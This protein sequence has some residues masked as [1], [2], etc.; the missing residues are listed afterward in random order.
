MTIRKLQ[1]YIDGAENNDSA[2]ETYATEY[3]LFNEGSVTNSLKDF[4]RNFEVEIFNSLSSAANIKY[5]QYTGDYLD[6]D[7]QVGFQKIAF[8]KLN[9]RPAE[10][11]DVITRDLEMS[12]IS[13]LH[14]NSSIFIVFVTDNLDI[15][16]K[17]SNYSV[18]MPFEYLKNRND[19]YIYTTVKSSKYNFLDRVK[20][21]LYLNDRL[22]I[23]RYF[24]SI[25]NDK[26]LVEDVSINCESM[27][28]LN[29]KL[30]SNNLTMVKICIDD[31][32][33]NS[34]SSN[35]IIDLK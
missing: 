25:S 4:S 6:K 7:I 16:H 24:P 27:E 10:I 1:I 32:E 17:L 23:E 29:L 21:R 19:L 22:L 31:Q 26:I 15:K 35:F 5:K 18:L 13:K 14:K 30:T 33:Y 3:S 8:C 9:I 20:Y 28:K 12:E 34:N 11:N 2:I